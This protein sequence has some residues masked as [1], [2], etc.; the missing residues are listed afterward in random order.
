MNTEAVGALPQATKPTATE[1]MR[2]FRERRR[3]G[4]RLIRVRIKEP[5][6]EALERLGYLEPGQRENAG[7][8]QRAVQLLVSDV[9]WM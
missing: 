8:L 9:P 3:L 5:E 4:V 7:S 2:A 6:I 1:R